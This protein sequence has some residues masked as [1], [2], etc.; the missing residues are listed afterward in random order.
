[1][2][3][4]GQK[5]VC[6]KEI[7]KDS[8]FLYSNLPKV[9]KVYTWMRNHPY[10]MG[11]GMLEN[12]VSFTGCGPYELGYPAKSFREATDAD[13]LDVSQLMKET[14]SIEVNSLEMA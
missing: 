4:K 11:M 10:Y 3:K 8:A 14:E 5:V 1:M 9:G 2:F 12:M 7:P 6:I 13:L